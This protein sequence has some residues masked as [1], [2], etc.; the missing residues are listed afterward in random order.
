VRLANAPPH[1][2]E[3]ANTLQ[4]SQESTVFGD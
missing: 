1:R 2:G 3:G 4:T